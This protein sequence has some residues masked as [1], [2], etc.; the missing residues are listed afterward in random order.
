MQYIN[1]SQANNHATLV[2]AKESQMMIAWNSLPFLFGLTGNT[3]LA[4]E[5][6]LS[7]ACK[8]EIMLEFIWHKY[9][10]TTMF[11]HQ[12]TTTFISLI[13]FINIV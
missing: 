9:L 3:A 2:F 1:A 13:D 4:C 12:T 7:R 8:F 6:I 11:D 10:T 5:Q